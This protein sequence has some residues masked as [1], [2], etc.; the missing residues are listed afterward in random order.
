LG[1]QDCPRC[2]TS[3]E[4]IAGCDHI[5]CQACRTHICWVC[6]ATFRD[7]DACYQHLM[8]VHKGGEYD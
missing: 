8:A 4:K 6:M 3:L 2:E 7:G 1:V 5:T